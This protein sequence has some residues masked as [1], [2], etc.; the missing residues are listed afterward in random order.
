[1]SKISDYPYEARMRQ[2]APFCSQIH[3]PLHRSDLPANFQTLAS[4]IG[5]IF[6]HAH[7]ETRSTMTSIIQQGATGG[8][9]RDKRESAPQTYTTPL[10]NAGARSSTDHTSAGDGSDAIEQPRYT[11]ALK[12]YGDRFGSIIEWNSKQMS[13][14][15]PLWRAMVIVDGVI[16][17]A[18]AGNKKEAKHKASQIACQALSI[19][20]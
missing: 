19:E 9:H 15:P 14:S 1:M 4:R 20:V 8:S 2:L 3:A 10:S 17:E 16:F 18:T 13:M 6:A 12:E 11:T 5:A 7:V